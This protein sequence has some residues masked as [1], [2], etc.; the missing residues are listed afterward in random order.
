MSERTFWSDWE[1]LPRTLKDQYGPSIQTREA[2]PQS[3]RISQLVFEL[4]LINFQTMYYWAETDGTTRDISNYVADQALANGINISYDPEYGA[5]GE[6]AR[7]LILD[8]NK[9]VNM[10]EKM[11][12]IIKWGYLTG[13]VFGFDKT[14]MI[15]E[16]KLEILPIDSILSITRRQDPETGYTRLQKLWQTFEYQGRVIEAE[17]LVHWLYGLD[18]TSGF[19]RGVLQS[20]LSSRQ[21]TLSDPTTRSIKSTIQVPPLMYVMSMLI[22]DINQAYHSYAMPKRLISIEGMPTNPPPGTQNLIPGS[23]L[24]NFQRNWNTP[25]DVAINYKANVMN[26]TI[27]PGLRFPVEIGFLESRFL[28]AFGFPYPKLLSTP[29]FTEAS[30]RVAKELSDRRIYSYQQWGEG[31]TLREIYNPLLEYN[32]LSPK[33]A[34]IRIDWGSLDRSP[35]KI[36]DILQAAGI[37]NSNQ[38]AK[39]L[40][41]P[42][43]AR[44]L[45]RK[46]AGWNQLDSNFDKEFDNAQKQIESLQLD[47][48]KNPPQPSAGPA[49]QGKPGKTKV[50]NDK[51]RE[52]FTVEQQPPEE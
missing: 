2:R 20:L 12:N 43:E 38:Q 27:S 18:N 15:Q 29:G 52:S 45:L 17:R 51:T 10:R 35:T 1:R 5:K 41:R 34:G 30:M 6:K 11:W 31:Y 39:P 36:A 22:F 32:D 9:D 19:G 48:L 7:D 3:I 46:Q 16:R 33:K 50:T 21:V 49:T 23:E 8:F 47:L 42:S 44:E 24:Q 28:E 37:G 26:A 14:T 13:N 25:G 4:P 40:I